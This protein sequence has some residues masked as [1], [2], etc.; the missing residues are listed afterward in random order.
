M[1]IFD[2]FPFNDE[3]DLLELRLME[4]GDLVDVFVL[5][6]Q[7]INFRQKP[8]PLYFK[9]NRQRF[10][11]WL[12][13][14]RHIVVEDYTIAPHPAMD[15]YQRRQIARGM[16]DAKPH[17]VIILGD[18]DEIPSR[19]VVQAARKL[20]P[21][22]PFTC[23]QRLYYYYVN[24]EMACPWPGNVIAPRFALGETMDFQKIRHDRHNFPRLFQAG[25]HFSWL[26]PLENIQAKLRALD[27]EADAAYYGTPGFVMPSPEDVEFIQKCMD[28]PA[29]LFR[30]TDPYAQK[31]FVPIDPGTR[32][33]TKI[34]EWLERYPQYRRGVSVDWA[35]DLVQTADGT[36]FDPRDPG[37][38][39]NEGR[40]RISVTDRECL[41][42]A[43]L[44]R[45]KTVLEIGTGLG[46]S[47]R[48]MASTAKQ[49]TTVDPDPWV[50][51]NIWPVL[52]NNVGCFSEL[53]DSASG[54]N[55][56][57][58]DGEHTTEAC[59]RD[60]ETARS[61]MSLG[62][63]VVVHDYFAREVAAAVDSVCRILENYGGTCQM[64][65]VEFKS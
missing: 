19:D 15:H 38:E 21:D 27:C 37:E 2:G 3:L 34:L 16:T 35:P 5:V 13:K 52:P 61:R 11:E 42:L 55:L 4:L 12:P 53:T 47:T 54:F 63:V 58:I 29:D 26:G 48:A 1:R 62:G 49:V 17:D 43:E 45:H 46:I 25:W 23:F 32:Q 41:I 57:F 64:V 50:H 51:K 22:H 33:P 24:C 14:I 30:R 39:T 10:A 36:W 44:A 20:P 31:S 6:E 56:V 65:R 9:E 59:R 18:V 7:D 60:L 40:K 8:K 28:E